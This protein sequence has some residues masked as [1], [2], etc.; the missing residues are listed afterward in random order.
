ME[1]FVHNGNQPESDIV[2]CQFLV[3]RAQ[4][5]ILLVPTHHSLHDVPPFV[6]HLVEPLIPRLVL[7]RRDDCLNAAALTPA[8]DARV[9]VALVPRQSEG[10]APLAPTAME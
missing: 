3:A 6:R 1:G 8:P 4:T 2:D 7:P 9:A 10:P 5:A